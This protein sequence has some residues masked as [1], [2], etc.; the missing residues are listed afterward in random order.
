MD[1]LLSSASTSR[2]PAPRPR[3]RAASSAHSLPL[4][5]AVYDADV[6]HRAQRVVMELVDAIPDLESHQVRLEALIERALDEQDHASRADE[7]LRRFS[8]SVQQ[9]IRR[10]RSTS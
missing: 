4:G 1:S 6:P 7:V 3:P 9:Y 10:N 5:T 8:P 2:A